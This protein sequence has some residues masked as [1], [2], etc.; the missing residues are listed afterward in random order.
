MIHA[1][2]AKSS[3][4]RERAERIDPDTIPSRERR[5]RFMVEIARSY[6]QRRDHSACLDWLARAYTVSNDSVYFSP[7]ARQMASEVVDHGG[8]MIARRSRTFAQMLGLPV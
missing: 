8:P 4:A 7:T 2:L 5:G 3:N 6:Q 1:D